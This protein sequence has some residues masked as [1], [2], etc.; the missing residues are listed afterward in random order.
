M[1]IMNG[2]CSMCTDGK[3]KRL[4]KRKPP[5]CGYHYVGEQR[6]KSIEKNK[7]K[8]KKPFKAISKG[9]YKYKRKPTGELPIMKEIWESEQEHKSFVSGKRIYV[10]DVRN[11]A[12]VLPKAENRFYKFK[13]Y[14]KNIKI[15]TYEEHDL[16]DNGIREELRLLPEWDKMF[17][18]EAE[19]IQEYKLLK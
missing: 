2:I 19:L 8:P 1:I 12:H 7:D 9:T 4:A 16:W 6:K 13:L 17:E 14:P 5:L 18:L 3:E 11:M 15:L 10:F